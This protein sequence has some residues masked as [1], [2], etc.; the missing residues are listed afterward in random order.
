VTA[1]L[2]EQPVVVDPII[3]P[4]VVEPPVGVRQEEVRNEAE[5]SP[6]VEAIRAELAAGRTVRVT[7]E[8]R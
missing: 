1:L 5:L 2:A 4:L 6:V 8:P 7:W 3:E